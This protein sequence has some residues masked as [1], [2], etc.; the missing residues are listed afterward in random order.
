MIVFYNKKRSFFLMELM[1]AKYDEVKRLKKITSKKYFFIL[2][3]ST[4][5]FL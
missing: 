1:E 2:S 4:L 3:K 5:T